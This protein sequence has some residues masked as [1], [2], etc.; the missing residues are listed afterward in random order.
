MQLVLNEK[1]LLSIG[2][3]LVVSGSAFTSWHD[4]SNQSKPKDIDVFV[5]HDDIAKHQLR[6]YLANNIAKNEL[7]AYL[8]NNGFKYKDAEYLKQTNPG[9]THVQDVWEAVTHGIKYKFIFT[10]YWD[11]KD[12]IKEFDYKHCMV[13]YAVGKDLIYITRCIYDAIDHKHLIV[14]NKNG[15]AEWRRNK[16]ISRGFTEPTKAEEN[17]ITCTNHD[18]TCS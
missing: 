2:H 12:L 5:L 11:R 1:I 9:A 14:N 15:I 16:F 18:H 17:F 6:A 4:Q 3:Y 13:S 8:S 7:R 10:D